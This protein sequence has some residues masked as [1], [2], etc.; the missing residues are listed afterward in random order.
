MLVL[1]KW[2]VSI[3]GILP[4]ERVKNTNDIPKNYAEKRMWLQ[5]G[6]YSS[7]PGW[8]RSSK[9]FSIDH[10]NRPCKCTLHCLFL[11]CTA[12]KILILFIVL[13]YLL[14]KGANV[15]KLHPLTAFWSFALKLL[16]RRKLFFVDLLSW[17]LK[18][19]EYEAYHEVMT[20]IFK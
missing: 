2:S 9:D 20:Q 13:A 1:Q 7:Q 17:S 14:H 4:V 8:W 6:N 19:S 10:L 5:D 3:K 11:R 12:P 16:P 15:H 18:L